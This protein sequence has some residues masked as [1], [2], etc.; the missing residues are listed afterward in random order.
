M[1]EM[2]WFNSQICGCGDYSNH[3]GLWCRRVTCEEKIQFCVALW[4]VVSCKAAA[5]SLIPRVSL[6]MSLSVFVV[7]PG[8]GSRVRRLSVQ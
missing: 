5:S 4:D 8:G 6:S 2:G 7:V 3:H 1:G